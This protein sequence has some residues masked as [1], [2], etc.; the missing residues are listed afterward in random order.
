MH[1][2]SEGTEAAASWSVASTLR[3]LEHAAQTLLTV[4]QGTPQAPFDQCLAICI[5]IVCPLH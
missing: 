1:L 2:W 4:L 5:S 3:Y